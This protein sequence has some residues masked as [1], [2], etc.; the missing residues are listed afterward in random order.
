VIESNTFNDG[1]TIATIADMNEM[2]FEGKV[3]E[4]EVG[5]IREG[6]ELILSIGAIETESFTAELERIAPKGVEENG[7][8]QF[9]IRAAVIL[10]QDQFIRAGY[11]ANADIVL[12]RRE[13]VL[14]I[15]ESLLKFDGDTTYVEV[16]TSPQTYEKRIIKTGL[17]DGLVIEILEGLEPS[18][19]IKAA[20]R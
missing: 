3:D 14:A 7:A 18:D 12:E 13:N 8:I 6:M 5:K 10:K 19:K 20:A 15:N 16:E 2:I 1:T 9:A 4:S 11:S 17:S